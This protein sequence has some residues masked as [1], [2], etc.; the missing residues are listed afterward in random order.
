MG[1]IREDNQKRSK[2]SETQ[3]FFFKFYYIFKIILHQTFIYE[4]LVLKI[5][6]KEKEKI[7]I[8]EDLHRLNIEMLISNIFLMIINFIEE[9]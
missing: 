6:E 2:I 8:I 7:A 4:D 5:K 9:N 3:V 1:N